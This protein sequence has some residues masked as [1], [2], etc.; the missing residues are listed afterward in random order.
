MKSKYLKT[1]SLFLVTLSIF[2]ALSLSSVKIV[3]A[4]E[5][6][7]CGDFVG[8]FN[9][10][11]GVNTAFGCIRLFDSN[12]AAGG[13]ADY[14]VFLSWILTWAIGLGLSLIHI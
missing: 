13:G 14:S 2:T 10:M 9:V 6:P 8:P 3:S 11:N 5:K 1:L 4:D 12:V 7:W